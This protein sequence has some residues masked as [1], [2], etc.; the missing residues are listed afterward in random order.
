MHCSKNNKNIFVI[1]KHVTNFNIMNT[2][3]KFV[4]LKI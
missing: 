4:N 1:V 2:L 3:N